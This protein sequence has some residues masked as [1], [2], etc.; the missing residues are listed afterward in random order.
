MRVRN[1]EQDAKQKRTRANGL[2]AIEVPTACVSGP[3]YGTL[4]K[5]FRGP[6]GALRKSFGRVLGG[7]GTFQGVPG[8]PCGS[9]GESS[10]ALGTLEGSHGGPRR[11]L[12]GSR[13][14]L[15]APQGT[16][17]GPLGS[18]RSHWESA[19]AVLGRSLVVTGL[20]WTASTANSKWL[21][22]YQFLQY[23]QVSQRL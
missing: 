21:K 5:G 4:W 10:S 6:R 3:G 19:G 9:S 18:P 20:L 15:Q 11:L 8:A 12:S 14:V 1:N 16:L 2:R 17:E 7:P 22:K 13:N 23:F